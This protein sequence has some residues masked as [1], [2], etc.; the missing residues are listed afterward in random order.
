MIRSVSPFDG[1]VV[2]EYQETSPEQVEMAIETAAR[3]QGEWEDTPVAD[4]A[5][6]MARLA[7]VLEQQ[8]DDLAAL[9]AD[10]MGKPLAQGSGEVDKCAWVCRHY[11]E[12]TEQILAPRHIE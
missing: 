8:R 5:R 1:R 7:E 6:P 4:R 11:A 12:S 9:M 3:L 10:E 2:A